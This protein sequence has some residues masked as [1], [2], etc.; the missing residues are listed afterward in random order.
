MRRLLGL[1]AVPTF[2]MGA[3]V[4]L[5]SGG[6]L[7]AS[8]NDEVQSSLVEDYAYPGA[9]E[10]FAEHGLQV[11]RGDGHIEFVERGSL[12]GPCAAGLIQVDVADGDGFR[13][14]FRTSGSRGFLELKVPHTFM[15]RAGSVAVDATAQ[16]PGETG[17]APVEQTYA[18][19]PN[20]SKY[21]APSD[22]ERAAILVEL[23]FGSW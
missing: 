9:D 8:G 12:D 7:A 14:C 17:E 13:Y 4:A 10:L 19:A 3:V 11:F 23:R 18:V 5:N 6:A 16:V 2:V 1:I 22:D 15:L 21:I 20:R